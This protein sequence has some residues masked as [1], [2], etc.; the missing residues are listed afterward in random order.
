[1]SDVEK[2][3]AVHVAVCDQR[4][5]QIAV[6]NTNPPTLYAWDEPTKTWMELNP[7]A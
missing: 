4:Y 3:F 7:S 1:M 6:S 5:Q 2:D